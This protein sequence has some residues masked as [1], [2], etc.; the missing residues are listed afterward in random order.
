MSGNARRPVYD[1]DPGGF[2]PSTWSREAQI[3]RDTQAAIAERRQQDQQARNAKLTEVA[4]VLRALETKLRSQ[5]ADDQAVQDMI[6]E[7]GP[8]TEQGDNDE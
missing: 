3:L 2:S 4:T 8:I 5:D 1:A 7:G 6:E